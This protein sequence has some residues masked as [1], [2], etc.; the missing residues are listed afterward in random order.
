MSVKLIEPP[1]MHLWSQSIGGLI[2][3]FGVIEFLTLRWIQVLDGEPAAI[4]ARKDKLSRRIRV[5]VSLIPT[6][7]FS[8]SEKKRSTDL[9]SEASQLSAMRNRIAHNPMC[10]GIHLQSKQ[11]ELSIIE[12]QKMT[13]KGQNQLERLDYSQIAAVALRARDI[14]RDLSALIESIP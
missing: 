5:A 13:P 7:P 6:S 10:V 3:N 11:V 14:G 8:D 9:W 2:I 12:L 1:N 4:A